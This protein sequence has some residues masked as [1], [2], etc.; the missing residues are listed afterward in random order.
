MIS[1]EDTRHA[2]YDPHEPQYWDEQSLSKELDRNYDIC[3]G[4][5]LCFKF[6]PTFPTLFDALDSHAEGD[7]TKLTAQDNEEILNS[8]FQCKLCYTNCP[9][10]DADNH[11]FNMDFPSLL[12]RAAMIRAKKSGVSLRDKLFQDPDLIGKLNSGIIAPLVNF[13][14]KLKLFRIVLEAIIGIHR[15]KL[16]PAFHLK[17]FKQWF[18][19]RA[20]VDSPKDSVVLFSTCYVNYN[21]P[22]VGKDTVAV[23]EKNGVQVIHPEAQVCCGQPAINTGDKKLAEKKIKQNIETLLPEVEAGKKI[24]AINPTCSMTLKKEFTLMMPPGEWR[25]KAEKIAAATRDLGEYLFELKKE[26]NL[27]RDYK[28]TPGTVAYHVPCH[29][30]LQNIGYRS[31]DLMKT[32][33]GANVKVTTECCGHDGTWAM[34]KE[35]FEPS[36]KVGKKAFDGLKEANG[37]CMSSDCPLAALQLKQGT[38]AKTLP[39]HPVQVLAKAYK[40]PQDGGYEK[41]TNEVDNG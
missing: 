11:A 41:S 27:S 5:R 26:D 34:K 14:F 19:K 20:A 18:K 23:L 29:L 24:I 7:V 4:C 12:Q 3:H 38:D 36:L 17:T 28:S 9:Y 15:N 35:Y 25:D 39:V 21:N 40:E 1:Y 31:R 16:M 2:I 13:F 8:C 10:T 22:E 6:C 30:R 37:N 32:I 33:P